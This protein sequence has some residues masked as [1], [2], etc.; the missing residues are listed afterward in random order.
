MLKDH[1]E[2][3][4]QVELAAAVPQPL[5]NR[6]QWKLTASNN[7]GSAHFAVDGNLR[8][9]YDTAAYQKPG[10]WFQIELPQK[11]TLAGLRL[12]TGESKDDFP[13]RYKLELSDDGVTWSTPV[14]SGF[15]TVEPT[16]IFFN[17]V[18]TKF[19][20]ITQTGS[21]ESFFWS[22]S[23]LNIYVPGAIAKTGPAKVDISK[24]E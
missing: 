16:D 2:P 18:E 14:V 23:E 22:I 11:T 10:M 17:P 19:I 5:K 21:S 7:G 8:T 4:T 24:F 3:W 1:N 20:R 15:G 12:D 9:R 13:K 6:E